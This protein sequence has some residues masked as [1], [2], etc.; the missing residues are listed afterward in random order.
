MS[1]N[2]EILVGVKSLSLWVS[3][4]YSGSSMTV[5]SFISVMHIVVVVVVVV[6]IVMLE[7][8]TLELVVLEPVMLELVVLELVV[9]VDEVVVVGGICSVNIGLMPGI[10]RKKYESISNPANIA[11]I[12]GILLIW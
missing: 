9:V 3:R 1:L 7:L 2:G 8:V 6:V 4:T 12:R 5:G 11:R 10:S